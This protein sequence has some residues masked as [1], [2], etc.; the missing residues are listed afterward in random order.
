MS[1]IEVTGVPE[2]VDAL[3]VVGSRAS[4]MTPVWPAVYESF[5]K[6]EEGRF[7]AEGP[8][9][10]PLAE[11][12]LA[13]KARMGY[14]PNILVATGAL[15]ASLTKALAQGAVYRPL[16]SSLEMGTDYRSPKQRGAWAGTALGAFHQYG[17]T[18][19]PARP[20]IDAEDTYVEEW[21]PLI[22]E[23]L[24]RGVVPETVSV[25]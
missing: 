18:R 10:A 22:S 5:L 1:W 21:G 9:W 12:T 3:D 7:D 24:I 14:P 16:P 23:W 4:D 6:G 11:S 2:T 19:M 13:E 17:T 15:K 20:I 8:G 25:A